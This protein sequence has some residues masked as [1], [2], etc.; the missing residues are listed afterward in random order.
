MWREALDQ[1]EDQLWDNVLLHKSFTTFGATQFLRDGEAIFALVDRYIPSGS[2][3]MSILHDGMRL[4]CLPV[5][6]EGEDEVMTLKEASDRVYQDNDEAR[7]VLEELQLSELT[8]QNARYI[9]SQRVE[10]SE[11]VEW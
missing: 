6:A 11:N 7:K 2:S 8:P 10:N 1:L 5:E 3:A 9:L 4:L